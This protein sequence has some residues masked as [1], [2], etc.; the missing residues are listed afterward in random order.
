MLVSAV[1]AALVVGAAVPAGAYGEPVLSSDAFEGAFSDDDGSV[2]EQSIERIAEWGIDAGCGDG[3]FCPARGITR[4]QMAAW[5]YGAAARLYGVPESVE[6]IQ[7]L[8]VADDVWYRPYVQWAVANGV[9]GVAEGSFDPDGAVTRADAA[10]MLVA[11]FDHLN[12]ASLLRDLFQDAAGMPEDVVL[13]MEGL[14]HAGVT[15]GCA[16]APLRYC[17]AEK[18]T[19]AATASLLARAVLLARVGLVINEPESAQGYMIFRNSWGPDVYLIDHLGREVHTWNPDRNIGLAKLLATGNL[20]VRLGRGDSVAIAEIDRSGF[21]VW[22]YQL[23]AGFFHH[24]FVPLPN[25]N[26]LLLVEATKTPE[27]AIAAGA[28]PAFISPEGLEY[29]YLVEIK[30]IGSNGGEVVWEWSMWDHLIQD[31]DPDRENYGA[32]AEHPERIDINFILNR[33][34]NSEYRPPYDWTHSN[35]IDYNPA[36]DQIMLSPR[37]YSELWVIDH[38]TTT[39]EAAGE[40]GDLLYRWGNPRA[41]RAGTVSD[42]QLFWA[43]DTHWIAPGLP[44]E[45]NIL[46]FNNGD[47]FQGYQRWYSSVDEIIPPLIDG[48]V[49]SRGPGTAFGPAQPAWTYTAENPVDFYARYISGA[50]RLPNGNTLILDG[51][52][53]TAFQVTPDGTTVWKYISPVLSTGPVHQGD[54][55][56]I[57]NTRT[58]QTPHG[59]THTLANAVYRVEWYPPDYPGLQGLDLTPGNPL[60]LDR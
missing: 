49:Y 38:S 30:P 18:A 26:V 3:R 46:V 5:L 48:G 42:Q 1:V 13:A 16:V 59:P 21:V 45:G 55:I 14:Y 15:K 57:L 2:H 4:A 33:L 17:P 60:E 20:M 27:E 54:A 52:Q 41:Y 7:F 29:D 31:H 40:K 6:E 28:D 56:P 34:Y 9:M 47:E 51:P 11:A 43:H 22:E 37:H 23:L 39:E 24:D 25:G 12:A 50:Q 53:G 10:E 19:R 35:A 44:G 58:R 36:L 8:D 32:V